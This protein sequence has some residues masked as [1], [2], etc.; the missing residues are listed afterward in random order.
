MRNA[1]YRLFG[2]LVIVSGAVMIWAANGNDNL[3]IGGTIVTLGGVGIVAYG[4][5]GQ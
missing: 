2:L 5:P 1:K 4:A 3:L